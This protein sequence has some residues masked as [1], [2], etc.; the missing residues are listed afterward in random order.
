YLALSRASVESC[1]QAVIDCA[2]STPGSECGAL[3]R[4]CAE[5]Q[6]A[7]S[8]PDDAGA[9]PTPSEPDDGLAP[10]V[11]PVVTGA[12]GVSPVPTGAGPIPEMGD[13]AE[14]GPPDADAGIP[15]AAHA[16]TSH[17]P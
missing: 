11:P 17:R 12:P 1:W 5:A 8:G 7:R 15:E 6:R 16:G 10:E 2:Q 13:P 14:A 4:S 3:A 9:T